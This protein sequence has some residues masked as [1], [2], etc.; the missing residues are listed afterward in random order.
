MKLS[1]GWL[2]LFLCSCGFAESNSQ[3]SLDRILSPNYTIGSLASVAPQLKAR[4][5]SF[6]GRE[7]RLSWIYG[8]EPRALGLYSTNNYWDERIP[9]QGYIYFV[10]AEDTLKFKVGPIVEIRDDRWLA[11]LKH[12]ESGQVVGTIEYSSEESYPSEAGTVIELCSG[13]YENLCSIS[14]DQQSSRYMLKTLD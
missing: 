1:Y 2:A 5:I 12:L 7:T 14:F 11:S 4:L 3:S 9:G 8:E 13:E 6:E 10:S